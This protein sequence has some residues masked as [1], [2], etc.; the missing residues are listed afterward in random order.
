MTQIHPTSI[1]DPKAKIGENVTIGPFCTIGPGV[2]VGDNTRIISHATLAGQTTLGKNNQIYPFASLGCAPQDKKYNGEKTHLEIGDNN[3]FRESCTISTGTVQD[4]GITKIGDNNLFMA[5]CHVGH[6]SIISNNVILANGVAIAGHVRV[7]DFA[8]V[9][10][11]SAVH[12]FC[13]VGRQAMIG[14]CSGVIRDVPPFAM[15]QG[16]HAELLGLNLT[17]LRRRGFEKESIRHIQAI[18]E[19][20]FFTASE[21]PLETRAENLLKEMQ[22]VAEAQEI[23]SFIQNSKRGLVSATKNGKEDI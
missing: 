2:S 13:R 8:I 20:L 9:G 11:L 7:D 5:T 19:T 1:I 22:D 15:V 21:E 18:Y 3:I 16:S 12:Q 23:F 6:D 10:G 17:G 14:G 4:N